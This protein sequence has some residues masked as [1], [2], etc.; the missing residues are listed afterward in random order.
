M[1][2]GA[3]TSAN[4]DSRTSHQLAASQPSPMQTGGAN[5]MSSNPSTPTYPGGT[6]SVS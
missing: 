3:G 2:P 6:T 5:D 4:D 1:A